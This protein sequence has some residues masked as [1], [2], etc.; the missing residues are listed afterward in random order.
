MGMV[1]ISGY[2]FDDYGQN[3]F[4]VYLQK[5]D[6]S[7]FTNLDSS[8]S[9]TDSDHDTDYSKWYVYSKSSGNNAP[10]KLS[11]QYASTGDYKYM[12]LTYLGTASTAPA[13]AAIIPGLWKV[14]VISSDFAFFGIYDIWID[15]QATEGTSSLKDIVHI[16]GCT[17]AM[18]SGKLVADVETMV[19]KEMRQ[20]LFER[21]SF[22]NILQ[23]SATAKYVPMFLTAY[24]LNGGYAQALNYSACRILN[25]DTNTVVTDIYFQDSAG[26]TTATTREID[27]VTYYNMLAQDGL[28]SIWRG[29][30]KV[31]STKFTA[32]NYIAEFLYANNNETT[33]F[34]IAYKDLVV[35][36]A[37]GGTSGTA[38]LNDST[39]NKTIIAKALKDQDVSAVSPVT[40]SIFNTL[41]V[42]GGSTSG[43]SLPSIIIDNDNNL[44]EG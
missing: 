29:F 17:M 22:P 26:A 2:L 40:G 8:A 3:E 30:I 4:C 36:S 23:P 44:I 10:K 33:Q 31:D 43:G 25:A 1:H 38:D 14:K 15:Y 20:S 41:S 9:Y 39:T 32:G 28:S 42:S 34:H 16:S 13:G 11:W 18:T 21:V 37:S 27:S 12:A 6:G 19:T 7:P 35:L 24:P 5:P